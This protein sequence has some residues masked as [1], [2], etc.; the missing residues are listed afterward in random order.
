[1]SKVDYVSESGLADLRT[2]LHTLVTVDRVVMAQRIGEAADL[3]DL[4]ENADYESAK[5]ARQ[6]SESVVIADP[7]S[8]DHV[9]VGST[10][11]IRS[12]D[13]DETYTIVGSHEARPALGRISNDSPIGSV[14]L[15]KV[16][17]AEIIARTPAGPFNFEIL[18]IA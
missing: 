4:S 18:T 17:G 7:S 1:M 14:M 13:G 11:T 2:E 16:V 5:I 9:Q 6:L 15:G 3:G 8:T 12:V 10:V